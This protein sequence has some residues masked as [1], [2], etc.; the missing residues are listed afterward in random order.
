MKTFQSMAILGGLLSLGFITD[1]NATCTKPVGTY[2]G[3]FSGGYYNSTGAL[4][5]YFATDITLTI[6]AAGSGTEVE[7][8][9]Q[10]TSAGLKKY[11]FSSTF[12]SFAFVSSTCRGSLVTS[13]GETWIFSV[14][15][16]GNEIQIT[17]YSAPTVILVGAAVLK[18]V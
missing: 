17:D 18:K 10:L 2:A 3:V 6:S 4:V 15:D 14:V 9:K 12:P 16:S 7:Y 13:G 1:A 5:E 8:G 11:T